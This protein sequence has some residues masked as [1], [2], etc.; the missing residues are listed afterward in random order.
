MT[1]DGTETEVEQLL[2]E[3]VAYYRAMAEEYDDH[4]LREAGGEELSAA[5]EAFRADGDVLELAC[6]QGKWTGLLLTHADSITCVDAS[7]EML[8]IARREV[9]DSRATFIEADIF[10]WEPER[11]YNVV[12]FAFWLSHVPLERFEAFWSLVDRCLEPDGR[13]LFVDDAYRTPEELIEGEESPTI[14]RRLNDGRA[15]RA[16][17]VPHTT[18]ELQQRLERI[19]W[20]ISVSQ[21][22]GPF[23]WGAGGR[24]SRTEV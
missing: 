12:F 23:F 15:F 10:G 11:R 24:A 14:Q 3:Q 13:V 17:K 19:G 6:G 2:A 4:A 18:A 5:L 16:V 8:A 1:A 22:A 9:D 7:P 20:R 21:T